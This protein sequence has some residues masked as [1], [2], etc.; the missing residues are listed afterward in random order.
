MDSGNEQG[1]THWDRFRGDPEALLA[2]LQ[3]GLEAL[4]SLISQIAARQRELELD[5]LRSIRSQLGEHEQHD[6]DAA[7]RSQLDK[8]EQHDI[9]AA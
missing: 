1:A 3:S 2:E 5:T 9:D 8:H 4:R 6:I 7:I